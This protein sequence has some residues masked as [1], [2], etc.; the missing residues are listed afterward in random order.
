MDSIIKAKEQNE[1]NSEINS[2]V[3]QYNLSRHQITN[4]ENI[5]NWYYDYSGKYEF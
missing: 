2:R 3:I 1:R 4:S 5:L